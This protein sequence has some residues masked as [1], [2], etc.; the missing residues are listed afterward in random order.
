M[1]IIRILSGFGNNCKSPAYRANHSSKE[2]VLN[3]CPHTRDEFTETWCR[4][5]HRNSRKA[6]AR[7]K[8][9][10][11]SDAYLNH[12]SLFCSRSSSQ[13]VFDRFSVLLILFTTSG[14]FD[15]GRWT[16]QPSTYFILLL[17]AAFPLDATYNLHCSRGW[18]QHWPKRAGPSLGQLMA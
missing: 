12:S 14:I 3:Y 13:A 17:C 10:R 18:E 6:A 4:L 11:N 15:R 2:P 16:K 5:I 8:V 9:Q 1:L 7:L